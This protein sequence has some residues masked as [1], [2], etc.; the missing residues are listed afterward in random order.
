M[1]SRLAVMTSVGSTQYCVICGDTHV[2]DHIVYTKRK[3]RHYFS[4]ECFEKECMNG[5]SKRSSEEQ[6]N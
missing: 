4:S 1:A 5:K 2:C 6:D 3:T